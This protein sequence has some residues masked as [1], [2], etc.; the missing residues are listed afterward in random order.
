M[1]NEF[2]PDPF[3]GTS[4]PSF[5]GASRGRTAVK[6]QEFTADTSAATASE[7]SSRIAQGAAGLTS[8]LFN[9]ADQSFQDAQREEFQEAHDNILN[10]FGVRERT[11]LEDTA[12]SQTPAQIQGSRTE[13]EKMA[14]A[15]KLGQLSNSAYWGRVNSVVRQLRAK[16]PAYRDQIDQMVS[17]ITGS[18]PANALRRAQMAENDARARAQR[19]A[20]PE[21]LR[22]QFMN[23][24]LRDLPRDAIARE[25]TP[26]AYSYNELRESVRKRLRDKEDIAV[27]KSEIGL[28][29]GARVNDQE[30]ARILMNKEVAVNVSHALTSLTGSDSRFGKM[31]ARAREVQNSGGTFTQKEQNEMLAALNNATSEYSQVVNG[32]VIQ[33]QKAGVDSTE[34]EKAR[35]TGLRYIEDLKEAIINKNYGFANHTKNILDATKTGDQLAVRDA[36]PDHRRL[37][38]LREVYGDNIASTMM[39][40]NLKDFNASANIALDMSLGRGV[41]MRRVFQDANAKG[42]ASPELR[43]ELVNKAKKALLD[44]KSNSNAITI[45]AGSLFGEGNIGFLSDIQPSNRMQM[46]NTLTTP[47]V[48]D[49]MW[50]MR[51]VNPKVWSNYEMWTIDTFQNLYRQDINTANEVVINRKFLNLSYNKNKGEFEVKPTTEAFESLGPG[52]IVR[53]LTDFM[54]KGWLEPD[55]KS[56]IERLN[57]GLKGLTPVLEKNGTNPVEEINNLVFTLGVDLNAPKEGNSLE[58]LWRSVLDTIS[59]SFGVTAEGLRPTITE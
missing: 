7:Q 46:F 51:N 48:A 30:K 24:H 33:Y 54:E 40:N 42:Y 56:A 35:A 15:Q 21:K 50:Q 36:S 38:A 26:Q 29:S 44:P 6:A 17:G 49:K 5:L 4:A 52:N 20:D 25:G 11:N 9:V 2:N 12:G 18:V 57:A 28:E 13:L 45:A 55:A 16:Y 23:K 14:K 59:T 8:S 37:A 10:E 39:I 41:P 31:L 47:D 3:K 43:R 19:T 1:A 27:K 53:T 34:V 58:G 32:T 22:R